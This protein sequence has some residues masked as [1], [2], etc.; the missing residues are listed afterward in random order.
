MRRRFVVALTGA[1]GIRFGLRAIET[2]LQIGHEVHAMMSDGALRVA[3]EEEDL[4]FPGGVR[5][6]PGHLFRDASDAEDR[7][8]RDERERGRLITYDVRDIGARTASGTFAHDGMLIIPCS[9]NTLAAVAHGTADNLIV[10]SADATLKEGRRLVLVPRETPLSAIHLENM[11]KLARL[12]VRIVPAMPAFYPR[13]ESI[14]DVVDFIVG[15]ALD[16]LGVTDHGLY[17]RWREERS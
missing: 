16:A 13:P 14:D 17:P 7:C 4:R 8:T 12:G 1:S 5:A 11:L 10:R 15:R 3:E 9:M 2:L 6:L